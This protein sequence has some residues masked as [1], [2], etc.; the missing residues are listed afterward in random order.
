MTTHTQVSPTVLAYLFAESFA[1]PVKGLT[2]LAR[3]AVAPRSGVKVNLQTLAT[4]LYISAVM[5]LVETG[6]V[7]LETIEIKKLF[8]KE[9]V[10]ALALNGASSSPL[11]ALAEKLAQSIRVAKKAEERRVRNVVIRVVGGRQSTNYPWLMALMPVI[12]DA[13]AAGYVK[14]PEKKPGLMKAMFNPLEANSG[15]QAESSLVDTLES[16]VEALKQRLNRFEQSLGPNA[17]L[18]RKEI[19]NGVNDC[20][21]NS[22]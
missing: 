1:A 10:L 4:T 14:R 16:S 9:N 17:G 21:D 19:E 5:E 20:K 8:G 11:S 15:V 2:A 6:A 12:G 18:L 13:E 22:D 7:S 3:G